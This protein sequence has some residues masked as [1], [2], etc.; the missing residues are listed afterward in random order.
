MRV[1]TAGGI[2]GQRRIDL[3]NQ[4]HAEK[5]RENTGQGSGGHQPAGSTKQ[6]GKHIHLVEKRLEAH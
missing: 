3:G 2:A 5:S 1:G 6:I 4:Q